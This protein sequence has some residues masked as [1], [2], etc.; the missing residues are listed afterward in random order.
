MKKNACCS[1]GGQE[2]AYRFF[3]DHLSEIKEQGEKLHFTKGQVLFYQEHEP[4]GLFWLKKG[5]VS[6]LRQKKN[7]R[8][9]EVSRPADKLLGL[10]HLLTNTPYCASCQADEEVEVVFFPKGDLTKLLQ[11]RGK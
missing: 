6:F 3:V 8:S 5:E 9:P 10:I 7:S 1:L 11:S 4:Y 2:K